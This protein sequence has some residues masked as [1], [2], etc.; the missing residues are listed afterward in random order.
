MVRKLHLKESNESVLSRAQSEVAD[1]QRTMQV[2]G[3]DDKAFELFKKALLNTDII[4]ADNPAKAKIGYKAYWDLSNYIRENGLPDDILYDL[5]ADFEW[6]D[7]LG[8]AY[9]EFDNK[10]GKKNYV[11]FEGKLFNPEDGWTRIYDDIIHSS[12]N[13]DETAKK[14]EH[15]YGNYPNVVKACDVYW[16]DTYYD[17]P[18]DYSE[19]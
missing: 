19:K 5:A 17:E 13:P 16:T 14:L 18:S 12:N 11:R 10:Y 7:K 6:S 4:H 1:K 2:Y 15:I 3:I 9:K 8:N